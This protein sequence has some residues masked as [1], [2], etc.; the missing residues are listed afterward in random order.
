MQNITTKLTILS[1]LISKYMYNKMNVAINHTIYSYKSLATFFIE[2]KSL[3]IYIF[4]IINLL[5]NLIMFSNFFV[6]KKLIFL[7]VDSEKNN[8]KV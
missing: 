6:L 2:I 5:C 3:Y 4:Y 7:I 8:N 1:V